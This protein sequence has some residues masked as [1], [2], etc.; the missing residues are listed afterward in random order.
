MYSD[1]RSTL[2]YP[3]PKNRGM[4]GPA[5]Y[6]STIFV[7]FFLGGGGIWLA[8]E[9]FSMFWS[10]LGLFGLN[11]LKNQKDA[12]TWAVASKWPYKNLKKFENVMFFKCGLGYFGFQVV[13]I[14]QIWLNMKDYS[15]NIAFSFHSL[16]GNLDQSL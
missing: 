2:I 16:F 3:D 1:F 8:I 14:I 6:I 10:L 12:G 9:E 13:E 11:D 4:R 5:V 7:R 15:H